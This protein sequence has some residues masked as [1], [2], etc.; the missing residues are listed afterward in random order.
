MPQTRWARTPDGLYIAYQDVGSGSALVLVNGMY[1]HIEVYREWLQFARFVER[2]A[3]SLRVLHF[4]RRG[5]GMSDRVTDDP[6]L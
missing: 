6:P 3:T 2:L 1:S 4:D 5:A